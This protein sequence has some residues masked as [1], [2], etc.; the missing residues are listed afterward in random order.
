VV[1]L[2]V[3]AD[4]HVPDRLARIPSR[5]LEVLADPRADAILH[6]GDICRPGALAQLEAVARVIAVRGNRD[7]MWPGNWRLPSTRV[8]EFDGARIRLTHGQGTVRRYL[9]SKLLYP[10]RGWPTESARLRGLRQSAVAAAVQAT[11]YGHT[12]VARIHWLD[13]MLFFNPGSLAPDYFTELGPTLGLL[14]IR[15]GRVHPEII[16]VR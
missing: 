9:A 4:T 13:G 7:I 8:I 15:Q 6:A 1:V 11:V 5:A 10:V 3:V 12:H 16:T 2:G 14:R